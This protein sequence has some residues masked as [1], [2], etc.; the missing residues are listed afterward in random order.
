M[1]EPVANQ[2]SSTQAAA[3]Y[4]RWPVFLVLLIV[5]V[6]GFIASFV[7]SIESLQ[8][9]KNPDAALACNLNAT[10]NC[11][12]VAKHPSASLLGFPNSF[13]GIAAEAVM[14][15]VALLGLFGGRLPKKF[16][17]LMTIG[18]TAGW[19]FALWLFITSAFVI[20]ALCPWCLVITSTMTIVWVMILRLA[21]IDQAL[22]L[23]KK[24]QQVL[25]QNIV[26]PGLD[27]VVLVALLTTLAAI[28]IVK[29][30]DALFG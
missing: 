22:P 20:G 4:R 13:V 24:I 21:F 15:T 6:L 29:Y 19:L 18:V 3:Q 28:I 10:V 5:S 23:P 27:I 11:A 14:I 7:L 17:L 30:G 26:K 8:L 16:T 25:S 12:T 2:P 9:A 1:S